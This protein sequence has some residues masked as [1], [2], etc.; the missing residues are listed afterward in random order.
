[1][2][3]IVK[4]VNVMVTNPSWISDVIV[5]GEDRREFYFLY[6]GQ[7]KWSIIESV[8][9]KSYYLHYYPGN[10]RLADLADM[11]EYEWADFKE[12]IS[13][14]TTELGGREAFQSFKEL[15]DL[16]RERAYGMGEVLDEIL[17][18]ELPF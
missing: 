6:K 18:D 8:D 9:R 7:Y 4:A 3:K 1:M 5:S 13:Y 11:E 15:Y 14:N 16:V 2:S 12:L 17:K 10:Q